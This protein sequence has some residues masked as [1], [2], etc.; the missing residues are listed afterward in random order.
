MKIKILFVCLGNICRSTMAEGVFRDLI[1]KKGLSH[2]LECDSAGTANY[3]I[4]SQADKRTLKV[5]ADKGISLPHLGRQ[6][7]TTDF[8]QFDYIFAMDKNNLLDINLLY[9]EVSNPK[10]KVMM[11]RQFDRTQSHADVPDPYYGEMRD[12]VEVH[13]IVKEAIE[14]FIGHLNANR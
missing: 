10:A 1:E 4:G 3:H 5:L 11:M 2:Q 9:S 14:G 12:F 6:I 13:D 8:E 7:S